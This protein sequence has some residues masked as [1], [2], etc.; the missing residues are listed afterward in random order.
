LVNFNAMHNLKISFVNH[1]RVTLLRIILETPKSRWDYV[2][3]A[4]FL[5]VSVA[6]GSF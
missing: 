5:S 2:R 3:K 1:N 6:L 4:A